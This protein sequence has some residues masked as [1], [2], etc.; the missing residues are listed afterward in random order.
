MIYRYNKYIKEVLNSDIEDK[1]I[2]IGNK[3]KLWHYTNVDIT[4]GVI[5]IDNNANLHSI[6][7]FKAWSRRRAFFYVK[8]GGGSFDSVSSSV[9]K[10]IVY[11][12]L[13]KIYDIN[14]NPNNYSGNFEELYKQCIKDGYTAWVY[15]L[16]NK[17]EA[18]IVVS[19]VAVPI[20][21]SYKLAKGGGYID[22]NHKV[23]DYPIGKVEIDGEE[24]IVIQKDTF[25]ENLINTYLTKEDDMISVMNGYKKPLDFY[26]HKDVILHPEFIDKYSL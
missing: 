14:T 5:G 10:Y 18:P 21:E 19:F 26:R 15:Y 2:I 7:E 17:K 12:S 23:L 24:W 8:E 25:S 20:S 22:T 1:L 3:V 13:D 6:N 9:Y 11:I 4:N 16:G